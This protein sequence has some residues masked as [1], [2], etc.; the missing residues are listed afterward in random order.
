[1]DFRKLWHLANETWNALGEHFE[2]IIEREGLE[3]GLESHMWGL[4]LAV[5]TFEPE[6]VTPAHLMVRN[7]YTAADMYHRRLREAAVQGFLEEME[8]GEFRLT[9]MGRSA[10]LHIAAVGRQ[11]MA[12]ADPLSAGDSEELRILLKRLVQ[13]SLN[14][15]SPPDTWS[16]RLNCKLLPETNPPMPYTEQLFSALAAYRDDAH[17]AAWQMTGLSATA[18]ESLTLL[19]RGE[20]NSLDSLC[21]RL[22]RRGHACTVYKTALEELRGYG[23]I[24][25]KD[26]SPWLTGAGRIFRNQVEDDTDRMF[27]SPWNCLNKAD[28]LRLADLLDLAKTRLTL[29]E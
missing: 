27:F 19:W 23:L 28:S 29:E 14:T 25:G 24:N 13:S 12:D 9:S 2:P 1:M 4:L 21:A 26:D 15:P 22:E 6:A 11:A 16:I 8:P 3:F 10:T 20:V 5:L 7:P 17:L 18:L